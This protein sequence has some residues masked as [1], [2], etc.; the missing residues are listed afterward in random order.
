MTAEKFKSLEID[1]VKGVYK[2]NGKEMTE[3]S[4]L[5]LFF[6][7][8]EWSLMITKDIFF[9]TAPKTQNPPVRLADLV[10]HIEGEGLDEAKEKLE[11]MR[12]LMAE[13]NA[14]YEKTFKGVIAI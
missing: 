5:R 10:T 14:L 11:K 7:K 9:E 13:I 12:E 6:S 8:G 2:L 1:L 3:V 4:D